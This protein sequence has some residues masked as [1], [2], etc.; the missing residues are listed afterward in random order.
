[1]LV[2]SFFACAV[3][4]GHVED[5]QHTFDYAY[6]SHTHTDHNTSSHENSDIDNEHQ[7]HAHVTCIIGYA[8]FCSSDP[9]PALAIVQRI[10]SFD[11][12]DKQPPVPPP[13]A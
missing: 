5:T 9:S 4:V 12:N 2:H 10:I 13:N 8:S 1:M 6:Q 3:A 7:F 11:S